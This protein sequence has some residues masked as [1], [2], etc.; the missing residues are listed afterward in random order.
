MEVDLIGQIGSIPFSIIGQTST[1]WWSNAV[2]AAFLSAVLVS[3]ANLL[4]DRKRNSIAVNKRRQQAY[5]MLKARNA[6]IEEFYESYATAFIKFYIQETIRNRTGVPTDA[7]YYEDIRRQMK[8]TDEYSKEV[9]IEYGKL[10]EI[11]SLIPLI[12]NNKSQLIDNVESL[13]REFIKKTIKNIKDKYCPIKV[14]E[15]ICQLNPPIIIKNGFSPPDNPLTAVETQQQMDLENLIMADIIE[16]IEAKIK[17]QI[18][19]P[20]D[21][22]LAAMKNNIS[23]EEDQARQWW[24]IWK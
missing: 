10:L 14:E 11:L 12:F 16:E 20:V 3:F 13:N 22:L 4:I 7:I 6:V 1:P 19:D 5:S 24:Q 17:N 18:Q 23:T 9:D 15:R 2:V 8:R 21:E